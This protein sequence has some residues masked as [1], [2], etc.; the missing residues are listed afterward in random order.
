M[1]I[2]NY[3]DAIMNCRFCFM[4]RHL[5]AIGNVTF[6]EADT[7]RVRAAMT[8]GIKTGTHRLDDPDFIET[9]YRADLS[10]C[11]RH[12][13]VNHFDEAG[14]LLA[15]RA[16]IV[17]AGLAP[18]PVAALAKS[19]SASASW[20]ISAGKEPVAY[21]EDRAT[22]AAKTVAPAFAKLA[23]KAG[24][25]YR[26]IKGGCIGHA[27]AVLGYRDDAKA[28]LGAFAAF[29]QK[30][31]VGTLVVSNPAALKFLVADAPELGVKIPCK[32]VHSSEFIAGLK[33][34]YKPAGALYPLADDFLR[35]Y[36]DVDPATKLMKQLKAEAKPFGTNDE[37]TYCCG[38]GALVLDELHPELV[39][40]LAAYV[41]ARADDPAKDVLA[42]A[43]PYVRRVLASAGLKARTF[44]E[45]AAGALA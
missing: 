19:L 3:N 31:G 42:V 29:L 2:D 26:T 20:K 40:K 7:P 5:S 44:E 32:V 16:D 10:A 14:L 38:E 6:T 17:E 43:S 36:L 28:A 4:C 37:E 27:L 33:L 22:A 35:N 21:F 8:Y 25:S 11:C 41:A 23:K 13:C 39:A 24:V 18:A 34:A 15:L 30:T 45:I 9:V 1:H 12:L